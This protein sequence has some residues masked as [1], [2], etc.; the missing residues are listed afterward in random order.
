M[1]DNELQVNI[2][3]HVRQE[4]YSRGELQLEHNFSIRADSFSDIA[5]VLMKYDELS[6]SIQQANS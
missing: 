4:N 2:R 1:P 3:I 5:A 6:K